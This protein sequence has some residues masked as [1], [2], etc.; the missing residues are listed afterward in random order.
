MSKPED[1]PT[2]EQ[3][4]TRIEEEKF[5][6]VEIAIINAWKKQW[7]TKKWKEST[8]EHKRE[9]IETLIAILAAWYMP[10]GET[11]IAVIWDETNWAYDRKNNIIYG[12]EP[13]IIS[14]LHELG[15]AIHSDEELD[16]CAFSIGL[17]M[18]CF[19]QE[20]RRLSWEG[21]LLI[22]NQE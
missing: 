2:K 5:S 13:S 20:F 10:Y 11:N 4:L 15:H 21:H 16:A 8:T 3:I 9:A 22:K 18:K 7:Y 1:Y 12:G 14:T 19:P 17:F 6:D